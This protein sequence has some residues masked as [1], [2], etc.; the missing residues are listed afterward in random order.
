[1]LSARAAVAAGRWNTIFPRA[2]LSGLSIALPIPSSGLEA[3]WPPVP[4]S[5]SGGVVERPSAINYHTPDN[6]SV[7]FPGPGNGAPPC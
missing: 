2:G 1:M 5:E 6:F 4:V 7:N 3:G